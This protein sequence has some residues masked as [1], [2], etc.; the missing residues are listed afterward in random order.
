MRF[1]ELSQVIA[2][3][4]VHSDIISAQEED[5]DVAT[6]KEWVSR[7]LFGNSCMCVKHALKER[8]QIESNE[9][10]RKSPEVATIRTIHS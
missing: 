10:Q 3:E 7:M 4:F 6:V 9:P 2:D 5:S 8:V 1:E